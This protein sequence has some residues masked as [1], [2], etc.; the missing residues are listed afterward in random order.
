MDLEQCYQKLAIEKKK[1]AE[2]SLQYYAILIS[3][4]LFLIASIAFFATG[5]YWSNQIDI[6][7]TQPAI[8]LILGFVCMIITFFLAGAF[9]RV[10]L[11]RV[12]MY[13][14][15]TLSEHIIQMGQ[16]RI[17]EIE[18]IERVLLEQ[19]SPKDDNYSGID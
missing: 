11:K 5:Y 4:I 16:A 7:P 14:I 9:S 8:Y 18:T 15:V 13:A 1:Y 6:I 19:H 2:L 12:T 10:S 3:S 17:E